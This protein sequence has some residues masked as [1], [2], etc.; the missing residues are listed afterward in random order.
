[1]QAGNV[2]FAKWILRNIKC[3]YELMLQ[4]LEYFQ[5]DEHYKAFITVPKGVIAYRKRNIL[6]DE[7]KASGLNKRMKQ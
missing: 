4:S 6:Q 2:H 1:M 7:I 3:D 5:L